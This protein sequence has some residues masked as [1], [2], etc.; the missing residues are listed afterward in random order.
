MFTSN[1]LARV[2]RTVQLNDFEVI[3][4]FGQSF[5]FIHSE[6]TLVHNA[7]VSCVRMQI[8]KVFPICSCG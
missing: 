5:W 7:F 1:E 8:L 4:C 2:Y 3:T 6:N